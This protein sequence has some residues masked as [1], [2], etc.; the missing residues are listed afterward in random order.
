MVFLYLFDLMGT[1]QLLFLQVFRY[2]KK[3]KLKNA[4]KIALLYVTWVQ[5]LFLLLLAVV[6]SKFM[7]SMYIDVLSG[8]E[9]WI[10]FAVILVMLFFRNWMVYT[11]RKQKVLVAKSIKSS[12]AE[13]NIVTLWLIPIMG[14]LLFIILWNLNA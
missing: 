9:A 12:S 6:L 7:R 4:N 11:G 13:R 10:L 8:T 14:T 5:G 1:F 2:Y 3:R